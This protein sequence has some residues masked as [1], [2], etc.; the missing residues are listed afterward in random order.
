MV[1]LLL[2]LGCCQRLGCLEASLC[3]G[4]PPYGMALQRADMHGAECVV[5]G[6]CQV[7]QRTG[8]QAHAQL[9]SQLWAVNKEGAP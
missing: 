7:F 1:W 3:S 9:A 5:Y 4:L 8:Q 6:T 2:R